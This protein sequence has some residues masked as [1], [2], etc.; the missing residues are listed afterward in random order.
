MRRRFVT[1]GSR[2]GT[3]VARRIDTRTAV[4]PS[5]LSQ[6]NSSSKSGE[7]FFLFRLVD[8]VQIRCRYMPSQKRADVINR[9]VQSFSA[10]AANPCSIWRCINLYHAMEILNDKQDHECDVGGCRARHAHSGASF[11]P[12]P[13]V[14]AH[15]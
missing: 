6:G 3:L 12:V 10:T 9:G 7:V 5:M 14:H 11:G 2:T 4:A 13:D 15:R 8:S 1:N